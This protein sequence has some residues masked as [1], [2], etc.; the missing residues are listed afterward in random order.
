MLQYIPLVGYD[1]R[2]HT[3]DTQ[4][5]YNHEKNI[6]NSFGDI[7]QNTSILFLKT[8]KVIKNQG[9]AGSPRSGCWH[10]QILLRVLFLA[11]TA[12]VLPWVHMATSEYVHVH[13]WRDGG[14]R[15]RRRNK[16]GEGE[17][18][19]QSLVRPQPYP[20]DLI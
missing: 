5:Q 4:H 6:K 14:H 16:R 8:I 3:K 20:Y 15:Q 9:K 13:M 2:H 1:E 10:D 19:I 11:H 17:T 7:P 12:T 18:S